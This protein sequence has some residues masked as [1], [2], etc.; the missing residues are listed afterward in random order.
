MD[1]V[2]NDLL[3]EF[4]DCVMR[5]NFADADKLCSMILMYQEDHAEALQF[6]PIIR[7]GLRLQNEE[8]LFNEESETE[9]EGDDED[10]D[11]DTNGD[12]DDD[13]DDS[14]DDSDENIDN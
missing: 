4:L 9:S 11:E 3:L 5:R 13:D 8:G 7:E 2:P 10:S 12:Y 14:S 1:N 6:Q